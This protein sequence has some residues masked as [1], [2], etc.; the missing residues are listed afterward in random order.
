MIA[1]N[2]RLPHSPN[3]RHETRAIKNTLKRIP[4]DR[5]TI[6]PTDRKALRV[7]RL[8]WLVTR[9]SYPDMRHLLLRIAVAVLFIAIL[10][11][12]VHSRVDIPGYAVRLPW[13]ALAA[14]PFSFVCLALV[15]LNLSILSG[16]AVGYRHAFKAAS[17][18]M[19]LFL[20]LPSRLSEFAKPVYLMSAAKLPLAKGLAVVAVERFL[21]IVCLGAM[22]VVAASLM[23]SGSAPALRLAATAFAA[24]AAVGFC[25][26][27][28]L[29]G[30]PGTINR[31]LG[32]IPFEGLRRKVQ[33]LMVAARE[34]VSPP[35]L[36]GA[37]FV[38]ALTWAGSYASFWTFLN[39]AGQYPLSWSAVLQVFVLS[40][41]GLA[42][43]VA[44]GGLGTF[45]AAIMIG[46][47]AHGYEL[48]EAAILAV[49]F[50]L[51]NLAPSAVVV[52]LMVL[53][54]EV[55]LGTLIKRLR[56]GI[57]AP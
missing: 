56:G 48:S 6:A 4:E 18:V 27:V 54:D 28:V 50:R 26:I 1:D 43:A 40:T 51:A 47:S 3:V 38:C 7:R 17:L 25:G 53:R 35:R 24:T 5:S 21:D 30:M 41:I 14:M 9:K 23:V 20:I 46:L 45:E 22:A 36:A 55:N 52:V 42:V 8:A 12:A 49:A 10:G 29:L 13:G 16:G 39:V 44:P 33:A 57:D 32:W 31:I 2:L 19:P 15:A 37:L 11:W 34:T